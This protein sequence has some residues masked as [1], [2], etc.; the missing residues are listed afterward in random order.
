MTH[1]F[2]KIKVMSTG[3]YVFAQV[4]SFVNRYEFNTGVPFSMKTYR[5]QSWDTAVQYLVRNGI[6][7]NTH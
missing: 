2:E 1:N 4:L 5:R 3:K 7:S 6:L